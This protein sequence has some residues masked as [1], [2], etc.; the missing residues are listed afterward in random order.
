MVTKSRTHGCYRE[1]SND[2]CLYLFT[3]PER[4]DKIIR[5]PLYSVLRVFC[6]MSVL[7]LTPYLLDSFYYQPTVLQ[8]LPYMTLYRL[9]IQ[10]TE[11]IFGRFSKFVFGNRGKYSSSLVNWNW[12]IKYQLWNALSTSR[13]P[14]PYSVR[15]YLYIEINMSQAPHDIS[16]HVEL[17]I[18]STPWRYFVFL[19]FCCPYLCI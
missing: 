14:Y 17:N 9:Q 16:K 10:T 8:I 7:A 6:Q 2:V 1:R 12:S 18:V 3:S 13:Y 11:Y 19:T 4:T 5:V 15:S